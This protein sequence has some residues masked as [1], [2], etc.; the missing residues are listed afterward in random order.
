MSTVAITGPT[1]V[2]GHGLV[3]LLERDRR[4]NRVVGVARRPFDPASSGWSK[5]EYRQGD[6]R[7][8]DGL[9]SCF[10]GAGAVAHLAFAKFGYDSREE[11]R[12][13]NVEGSLNALHAAGAA[14]VRRFVFASSVAA[15][16]FRADNPQPIAED[17]PARGS[18]R[19]FYSREKAEVERALATASRAY[20]RLE[21]TILRPVIVLG[22]ATAGSWD[23][24]LPRRL[25]PLAHRVLSAPGRLP[26]PAFP[27]P[28]QFVHE[29][30]VGEAFRLA[31]LDG[32]A[33]AFNL[34]GDGL[35]GAGEAARALGLLA[36]PVPGAI[37]RSLAS[38]LVRLP[39]RPAA[40]EMAEVLTHPVIVDAGRAKRELGWRPRYTGIEALRSVA[41][42]TPDR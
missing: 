26:V 32:P 9:Q 2:F 21:L 7:D 30:D 17:W 25:R 34:A 15:Y 38:A 33:G 5:L 41:G 35:V 6:V 14:G 8:R 11:L 39:R 19:W 16:G 4:V 36:V 28:M 23:E 20:P 42:A 3:P 22:P 12:A 18:D 1:G 10:A 29:R 13:I 37:T 31:L 27:H 40:L 24:I